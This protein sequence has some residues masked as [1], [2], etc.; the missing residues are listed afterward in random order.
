MLSYKN[1]SIK[2]CMTQVLHIIIT[3]TF[4]LNPVIFT[5]QQGSVL[6]NMYVVD[7]NSTRVDTRGNV[8]NMY[9]L[10]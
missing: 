1:W 7:D 5:V 6:L 4:Y 9:L 8:N 3:L 2:N 10:S